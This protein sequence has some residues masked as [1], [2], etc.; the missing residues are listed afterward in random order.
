MI[1]KSDNLPITKSRAAS[2][3]VRRIGRS[4]RVSRTLLLSFLLLAMSC[5]VPFGD[6]RAYLSDMSHYLETPRRP[7]VVLPGFAACKLLDPVT[8]KYVWGTAHSTVLTHFVDNIDLPI[9][10][11]TYAV[12]P[13]RLVPRGYVGSRGPIN[14]A[15]QFMQGLRAYG[16]YSTDQPNDRSLYPFFYD[17]RLSYA[18]NAQ[19]LDAFI[20]SIRRE[21]HDPQLKVDL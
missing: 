19:H 21:H 8:G 4:P 15:W 6:R 3:A 5:G 11:K 9:D 16:L 12:E 13:D 18:V 17:W 7:V 1:A 14:I 10:E 2:L 20:E